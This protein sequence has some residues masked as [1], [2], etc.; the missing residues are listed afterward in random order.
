MIQLVVLEKWTI[1]EHEIPKTSIKYYSVSDLKIG[2]NPD[3]ELMKIDGNSFI[4]EVE[5]Y[6]YFHL[7]QDKIGQYEFLKRHVPDLRMVLVGNLDYNFPPTDEAIGS[8]VIMEAFSVYDIKKEDIVFLNKTNVWFE[9]IFYANKFLNRFLP[10]E[11]PGNPIY[12]VVDK[13]KYFDFNIEIAKIVRDLYLDVQKQK[14]LKV[15]VSRKRLNVDIRKMKNLIEKRSTGELK[16]EE[17]QLL[18]RMMRVYGP[19]DKDAEKII[20]QRFL[21]FEDEEKLENYFVSKGYTVIDP[22]R[23]TF[24]QQVDLF[25]RVTHVASIRGS[26]L[27][28]TIFCSSGTNV[29]IIDTSNKYNFEYKT[30]V[31]VATNNVY[32]IPVC[33]IENPETPQIFFSVDNIIRLLENHYLDR[34]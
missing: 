7:F 4:L 33:S 5:G 25:S 2:E 3:L 23:M 32:E 8:K 18:T 19:E 14:T 22:Y 15:F 11:L 6:Q 26:G 20:E 31:Q 30:I 16:T 12:G 13:D 21:K 29:F 27:Y 28:N 17:E 1:S 10:A 9:K 34:L 24:D